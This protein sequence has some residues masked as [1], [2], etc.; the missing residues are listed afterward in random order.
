MGIRGI[1][2]ADMEKG[3]L[4]TASASKQIAAEQEAQLTPQS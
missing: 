3:S 1:L 2:E 4:S